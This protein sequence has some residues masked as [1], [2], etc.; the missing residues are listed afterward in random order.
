MSCASAGA[1]AST[2]SHDARIP[3]IAVALVVSAKVRLLATMT[4]L[5]IWDTI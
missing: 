3:V 5:L 4:F 1:M 2:R